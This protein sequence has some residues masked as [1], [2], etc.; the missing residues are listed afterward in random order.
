LEDNIELDLQVVEES[1]EWIGG[2]QDR[3]KKRAA[4]EI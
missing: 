1:M 4:F 3:D 2:F